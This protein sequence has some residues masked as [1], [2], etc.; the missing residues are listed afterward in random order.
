MFGLH[1]ATNKWSPRRVHG[2]GMA[3]QEPK[4]DCRLDFGL[5]ATLDDA[6]WDPVVSRTGEALVHNY[7]HPLCSREFLV[8]A[9]GWLLPS[10]LRTC[11]VL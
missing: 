9:G 5:V 10:T 6:K 2:E 7:A 11:A 3:P 4:A 1:G 8:F